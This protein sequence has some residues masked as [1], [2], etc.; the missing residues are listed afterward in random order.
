[1]NPKTDK[2]W[3]FV[4]ELEDSSYCMTKAADLIL[5]ARASRVGRDNKLK[6]AITLL[7]IARAQEG[8]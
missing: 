6:Q 1:V 5:E 2:A 8:I 4:V 3:S 7:A